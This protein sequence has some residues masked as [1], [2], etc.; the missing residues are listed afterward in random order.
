ML[1]AIAG[2]RNLPRSG[3]ASLAPEKGKRMITEYKKERL[4]HDISQLPDHIV[5]RAE[6]LK[7]YFDRNV[8]EVVDESLNPLIDE[9]AGVNGARNIGASAFSVIPAGTVQSQLQGLKALMDN[10]TWGIPDSCGTNIIQNKAVTKEKLAEEIASRLDEAFYPMN[11]VVSEGG[12]DISGEIPTSVCTVRFTAPAAYVKGDTLTINGT[13][14]ALTMV[15][16]KALPDNAWVSGAVVNLQLDPANKKAFFSAGGADLSFITAA[17]EHIQSG[18]IGADSEGEP[19][20]GTLSLPKIQRLEVTP[21]HG[22]FE[23][24]IGVSNRHCGG[25]KFDFELD[26]EPDVLIFSFYINYS[27]A[28]DSYYA[29]MTY[30]FSD[31]AYVTGGVSL[32]YGAIGMAA[33]INGTVPSVGSATSPAAFSMPKTKQF[34]AI[35]GTPSQN[36]NT[37]YPGYIWAMKL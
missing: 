28:E 16:G 5:G 1:T 8:Y 24:V 13:A 23:T 4:Q 7:D 27:T 18:Y 31:I 12:F 2:A 20:A 15:N 30:V 37:L 11:C 35:F 36:V 6:Y 19:V 9:L 26:F 17:A 3:S 14:Y 32:G 25:A 22:S 34:S 21:T 10:A 33:C 29:N